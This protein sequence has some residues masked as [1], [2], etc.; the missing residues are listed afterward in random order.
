[1]KKTKS[2]KLSLNHSTIRVLT[3]LQ[4]VVGGYTTTASG[5][6]C[7]TSRWCVSDF[8]SDCGSC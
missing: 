3:D 4:P 8:V 1:M 6:T 7:P 2:R 5:N